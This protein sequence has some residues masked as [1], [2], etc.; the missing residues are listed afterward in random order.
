MATREPRHDPFVVASAWAVMLLVSDAPEIVWSITGG[1]PPHVLAW[2]KV[3]V[4]AALAALA[5]VVRALRPLLGY[6]IVLCVFQLALRG[7]AAVQAWPSWRGVFGGERVSFVVGYAGLYLL[8]FAVVGAV[9]V[10]LWLVKRRRADFFLAV[11][12]LDAP[13]RPIRWL[14]IRKGESWRV[15][16][17]IF[18]AVAGLAVLVPS[19]LA[20]QV[21]R[22]EFARAAP[23]ILAGVGFAAINAFNEEV[24][25]RA[26]FLATLPEAVGEGHALLLSAVFF[27]LAHVLYGSPPGIA[28]FLMT[29]FLAWLLGRAML[30]TKG[31]GWPW[32]IHFVPDVVIFGSYA[33]AWV[34]R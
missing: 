11:G 3:G 5:L 26:S 16:G 23:L 32:L 31:L 19:A 10:A 14:G 9:L 21:T 27:G 33:I 18:A 20:M 4:V 28:G 15:F 30:E 13:I 12:R 7:S 17:W 29:G 25:F 24:Y 22:G 6:A 1:E 2:A 34:R 8:D